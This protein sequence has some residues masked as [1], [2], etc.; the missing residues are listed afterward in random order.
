MSAAVASLFLDTNVLVY[1]HDRNE[2]VKGP[3]ARV[4]LTDLVAAGE[5]LVSIQVLSEFF[6][7]VTRKLKPPL[8]PEDAADE[9]RRLNR[10]ARVLPITWQ[11]V[12]K[13]LGAVATHGLP[14][15]DAQIWAAAALN[16]ASHVL[17][18]DFQDGRTIDGVLFLNPFSAN[19]SL[20]ALIGP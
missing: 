18:E 15:W 10:L 11:I 14:L 4:L 12:D 17:S 6:W 1:A 13:A 9:V 19:F 3:Q 7:T 5:P 2:P 8:P 16:G 20:A